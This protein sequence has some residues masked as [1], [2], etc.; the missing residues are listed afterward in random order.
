MRTD[1]IDLNM[2]APPTEACAQTQQPLQKG[3]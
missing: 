1:T 2:T 3:A